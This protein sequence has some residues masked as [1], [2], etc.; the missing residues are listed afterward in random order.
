MRGGFIDLRESLYLDSHV[1][2][3]LPLHSDLPI[4]TAL[5]FVLENHS[6]VVSISTYYHM[7]IAVEIKYSLCSCIRE[8]VNEGGHGTQ[9]TISQKKKVSYRSASLCVVFVSGP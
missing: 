5:I 1:R 6:D 7:M 2:K 9:C 4:K 8:F 3:F